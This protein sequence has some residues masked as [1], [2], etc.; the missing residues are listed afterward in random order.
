M[1]VYRIKDLHR[2]TPLG[3]PQFEFGCTNKVIASIGWVLGLPS[4]ILLLNF[5]MDS[6][7][8]SPET[9]NALAKY[10]AF[11]RLTD[12]KV[13]IDQYAPGREFSRLTRNE[14]VAWPWR[15]TI[16]IISWLGYAILPGRLLGGDN[17]NPYSDTISIYSDVKAVTIHEGG[18]AKDFAGQKLR[19]T[20]A[21]SY[22]LPV[23]TLYAEGRA[24]S[25][26]ISYLA[27]NGSAEDEE[28]GYKML[29]PAYG[30]YVGSSV[31]AESNL[32]S[33]FYYAG[34]VT[35]HII[36]HV[37]ASHVE[38]DR[39]WRPAADVKALVPSGLISGNPGCNDP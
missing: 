16:G 14:N 39:K 8:I 11:N 5:K 28:E 34:V 21:A 29:Y 35:G 26:A 19:G 6:H 10:L 9:V 27:A 38:E 1:E 17:Y 24:S 2:V 3:E 33:P 15:Y 25:D 20:Y 23:F 22:M 4:K 30:T 13:R 12:V 18:H 37:K 32:I 31:G 7:R 36:G